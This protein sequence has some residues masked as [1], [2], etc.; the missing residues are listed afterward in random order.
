MSP[1]YAGFA[2]DPD[3]WR[4]LQYD[5]V[6]I[7]FQRELDGTFMAPSV[8]TVVCCSA[9]RALYSRPDVHIPPRLIEAGCGCTLLLKY[10]AWHSPADAANTVEAIAVDV[11]P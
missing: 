2:I 6:G 7:V 4:Y 11:D 9:V 8:D 10:A 5:D 1:A 3:D